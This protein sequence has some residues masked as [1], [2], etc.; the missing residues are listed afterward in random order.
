MD[1]NVVFLLRKLV[2]NASSTFAH[3]RLC[4]TALA[5]ILSPREDFKIS[6]KACS[7]TFQLALLG[8]KCVYIFFYRHIFTHFACSLSQNIP[9][10]FKLKAPYSE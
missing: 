6:V 1:A 9:A 4:M 7:L 3:V 8:C 2:C 5:L 10:C